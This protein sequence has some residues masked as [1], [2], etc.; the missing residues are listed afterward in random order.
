LNISG[1]WT[2]NGA[3]F[4][5]GSGTVNFVN[6]GA[7]QNIN[8]SALSE[9]FN[10]VTLN[11]NGTN[12]FIGGSI[13]T[14]NVGGVLNLTSGLFKTTSSNIL[15][16]TNTA[17][18]AITGGSS[19]SYNQWACYLELTF[20]PCIRLDV[21]ISQSAMGAIFHSNWSIQ[22]QAAVL[23]LYKFR[24]SPVQQAVYSSLFLISPPPFVVLLRRVG[25]AV[26]RR[27]LVSRTLAVM[28]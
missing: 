11:K 24:H 23:Y 14:V 5:P 10:N 21:L 4:T 13:A 28:T 3:T 12:L 15:T 22:L 6:T 27:C 18:S 2:N 8:G 19:S 25:P 7:D 9:T 1:D 17:T 26:E 16:I 20:K